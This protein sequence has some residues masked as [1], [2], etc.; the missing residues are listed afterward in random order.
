MIAAGYF[1]TLF[2]VADKMFSFFR[3]L[4]HNTPVDIDHV[5]KKFER[6]SLWYYRTT[7]FMCFVYGLDN[8]IKDSNCALK[9]VVEEGWTLVCGTQLPELF[10]V[11][12]GGFLKVCLKTIDWFTLM[13]MFPSAL[14]IPAFGLGSI[15]MIVG[16]VRHLKR[17]L[18]RVKFQGETNVELA[19]SQL[20]N[21]IKYFI[22]IKSLVNNMNSS[23]SLLFLPQYTVM[24]TILALLEYQMIVQFS[25][26]TVIRFAGWVLMEIMI[27]IKGQTL[28]DESL[29]LAQCVYDMEWYEMPRELRSMYKIF[30]MS[31]QKPLHFQ[32]KPFTSLDTKFLMNVLKSSY[33]LM[34]F[35]R[36]WSDE[37]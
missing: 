18:A 33:S 11:R 27:C 12:L 17:M 4:Q 25:A 2:L 21:C 3:A 26:A 35:F 28:L 22:E 23:V 36:T 10:P 34:M 9:D 14:A 6:L 16:R 37:I 1:T 7:L 24:S 30:H 5:I 8:T 29:D 19:R 13:W 31:V 32:A 20:R 15:D